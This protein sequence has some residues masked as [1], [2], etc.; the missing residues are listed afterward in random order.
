[1]AIPDEYKIEEVVRKT[2][3]MM[4]CR[5]D[6]P[7]HGTVIIYMP[8]D[9]LP[10]EAAATVKRHLYQSGI[11]MRS[12][13][14]LYLP[15]VTRTL[16]VSQNPNEPYI[17]TEYS[18]YNLEKWINE[19]V[20]LKS[21]RIYQIFSK[22]LQAI[23]SLSENGWQTDRLN[24]Y[25]IKL[26]DIH[27][28]D[29]TITAL[30]STGFQPT[31][32][33]TIPISKEGRLSDTVALK[34]EKDSASVFPPTQTLKDNTIEK[35]QTLKNGITIDQSH[36][37]IEP[38]VTLPQDAALAGEKELRL[39]QRNIYIL[40]GMVYQLL[41]GEKYHLSDSNAIVNIR[42][43]SAKWRTVLDKALSP[44]IEER[45]ESYESM[46]RDIERALSRNKRIAIAIAPLVVLLLIAGGLFGYRQY[47][48][49]QIMTSEAGQAIKNFLDIVDKTESDFPEP[50]SASQEPNDD[51]IL[52]P[53]DEI[54]ATPAKKE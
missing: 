36:A 9:V 1:M 2:E 26:S 32:T 17:I 41:F 38:T 35:T 15:F 46:L 28:G 25:Q 48:R 19:G 50:S 44:S 27:E 53:F 39:V 42:K 52:K 4:V 30:L 7:I 8:D 18:K 14:Q 20:R 49:H 12:I 13:S 45:Y 5:A 21:K 31:V 47:H 43:L 3:N 40:G 10:S 22:V 37:G 51:S 24:P 6:H 54:A 29:V 16:E 34:T 33:G 23:M 11:Q